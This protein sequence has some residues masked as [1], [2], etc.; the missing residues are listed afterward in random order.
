M[1]YRKII[2][3]EIRD[4]THDVLKKTWEW[5]DDPQIREQTSTPN[6]NRETSEKWFESLKTRKDYFIKSLWHNNKPIAVMGLKHL[7]AKDGETFGYIGEKEYWGKTIGVQ[8]MEFLVNYGRSINL[9]SIYSIIRKTNLSSYKLNR[10]LGFIQ[11]G[12]K[13]EDN[14]I[15]RYYY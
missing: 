1:E 8:G 5:L 2:E 10:R 12:D 13:D 11:E 3:I 14:I 4:F 7:N 6:F 15:M 9:E